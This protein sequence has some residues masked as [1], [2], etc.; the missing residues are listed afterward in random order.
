MSFSRTFLIAAGMLAVASSVLTGVGC[1]LFESTSAVEGAL[2]Q[3]VQINCG[4][5]TA[6]SP[7]VAD[8]DFSGGTTINHANTID[9]SKV[10]NP[11]PTA[12]YQ[13]ARSG[14]FTYTIGGFTAG[15]TSTVRLH[16]A[17]TYFSTT[18][19]RVFNAAINGTTVLSNFD[20]LTVAAKNQAYIAQY[21]VPANSSGAYVVTLTTV[22]NS[23]L[24]SG[25]EIISSSGSDAG[26]DASDAASDAHTDASDA[27]SDAH[28]D[29]SDAASDAHTDASA[30]GDASE[31][32]DAP[33]DA[34]PDSSDAGTG[35]DS[36]DGATAAEAGSSCAYDAG[37]A[38]A[39]DA[40]PVCGNGYVQ[41]PSEQCDDGLGS[42]SGRRGCSS[43][44][45]VLDELVV[46]QPAMDGGASTPERALGSGRHPVAVG[47]STYAVAYLD[48]QSK[49]LALSLATFSPKAVPGPV[50]SAF[51]A[52]LTILPGTSPV[53]AGLSC[54]QYAAAWT[55]YGGDCD[56]LGIALT[57]IQAG[58]APATPT[59][60][61]TTTAFSQYDPDI[62][63]V[64]GQVVVAWVDSSNAATQPDLIFRTFDATTLTPTSGE[65]PL[66]TTA[67]SEADVALAPFAGS[68]AA[69]WRDDA[70]GLETVRV[71][72]GSTDW[73]VGPAF[74]PAPSAG[75]PAVA[76]LDAT[77]LLVTYVVGVPPVGAPSDGGAADA[78]VG[79][80]SMGAPVAMGSKV[81]VAVLDMAAPGNVAGTDVAA[82]VASAI[83]LSQSQPNLVVAG[84]TVYLAWHTDAALGDPN[85]EELWI[86]PIA[87]N[88]ALAILSPESPLPR[89]AADRVGDQRDVAL[90]SFAATTLPPGGALVSA[91]DDWGKGLGAGEGNEGVVTQLLP[92]APST[93]NV[94][95]VSSRTYP[96]GNL[97]GLAGADHECQ[98][99]AQAAGLPGTFLAYLSTSTVAAPTR[100]ANARGWVRTD[101]LPVADTIQQLAAGNIWYPPL[102]DETGHAFNTA[103][104]IVLTG[105]K[106]DGTIAAGL[107]CSD[108]TSSDANSSVDNGT[109]VAGYS[110]W[111]FFG[112]ESCGG[113]GDTERIY[114]MQSTQNVAVAQPQASGRIAFITHP[115][116]GSGWAP[117]G[118]LAAADAYCQSDATSAGLPGTYLALLSTSTASAASR[119]D[120][121]GAPWV[122]PD[123]VQVFAH[124]SDL[125][126][127]VPIAPIVVASDRVSYFGNYNVWNGSGSISAAGSTST[128]CLDWTAHAAID[129]GTPSALAINS[130]FVTLESGA[131]AWG[132]ATVGCDFSEALLYCLQK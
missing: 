11:A 103:H 53:V 94:M 38:P 82:T 59:F 126:A 24:L 9:T 115:I 80:A 10:T 30:A 49:P 56:E 68:W 98:T 23:G 102:L 15:A 89:T 50:V 26:T 97:G 18:G 28:T 73:T 40:S 43:A 114:C 124:A 61:N 45:Q 130:G 22:V 29:A 13:T 107:T 109:P 125:T 79:D 128:D 129:G 88:G 35:A 31:A 87:S 110:G 86:K 91:W 27:A 132:I 58:V 34:P 5:T 104:P 77:H 54:N 44:C 64:G 106:Y 78:T 93:P 14:T 92:T 120:L 99:M 1:G 116:I 62:L 66:A 4:S 95:F 111:Q 67:D 71:H 21:S 55:D 57:L 17:E 19:S 117:S 7:F 113:G 25:I 8:V 119:F 46:V 74:L 96:N 105:T 122:R 118:G 2:S 20:I 101:G 70:N 121:S 47:T 41:M 108:W 39:P 60:A 3:V 123:G 36:S 16:F 65:Q 63:A 83:G 72:T 75:R 100:F 69:A 112:Q 127:F 131:V 33:Y 32:G 6:V 84:A 90:A 81:Q 42:A 85:G 48:T 52:S 76:Q 37:S 51:N 12:V